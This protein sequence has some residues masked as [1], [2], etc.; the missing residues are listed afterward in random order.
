MDYLEWMNYLVKL[1]KD[2]QH[3]KPDP[4]HTF[5][6]LICKQPESCTNLMMQLNSDEGWVGWRDGRAGDETR[7]AECGEL[8]KMGDGCMGVHYTILFTSCI[9]EIFQ[10]KKWL[11]TAS[12]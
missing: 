7:K 4:S 2:K 12:C 3:S 6:W 8:L 1:T 9:F 10:N 5:V 11:S